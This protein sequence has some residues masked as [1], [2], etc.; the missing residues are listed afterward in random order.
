[1]SLPGSAFLNAVD[2]L[3]DRFAAAVLGTP[4]GAP[5]VRAVYPVSTKSVSALPAVVLEVQDGTLVANPGQWKHEWNVDVL[6]L[7]AKRPADPQRVETY[8]QKYLP[9]LLG[10]T[11]GQLK[12]GLGGESGWN[13]DKAIPTGWEWTEYMVG[14][15][16]YDAIRVPF[17]IYATETVALVP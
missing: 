16:E 15:Q 1:V 2:A 17:T 14:D 11:E 3:G 7:L 12:I 4:S 13:V 9:A 8:R 5:A 6:L 10:A